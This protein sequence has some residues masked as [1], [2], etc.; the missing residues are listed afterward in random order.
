MMNSRCRAVLPSGRGKS[1]H[2][3]RQTL[4]FAP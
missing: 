3:Q 1:R 4:S 2:A